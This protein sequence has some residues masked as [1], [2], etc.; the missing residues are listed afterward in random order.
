MGNGEWEM[1]LNAVLFP[2]SWSLFPIFYFVFENG[3]GG[4]GNGTIRCTVACLLLPISFLEMG[5]RELEMDL[6]AV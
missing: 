6:N 5:N 1:D 3:K 2:V 4:M